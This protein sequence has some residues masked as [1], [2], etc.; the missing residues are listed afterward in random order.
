MDPLFLA[1][2]PE[3][4]QP[5]PR[6]HCWPRQNNSIHTLV[7]Q[8]GNS[9]RHRKI[10]FSGSTGTDRK[11]HVELR[12]QIEIAPLI[13]TPRRHY[14]LPR[15]VE[16]SCAASGFHQFLRRRSRLFQGE[17]HQR[18]DFAVVEMPPFFHKLVVL[19]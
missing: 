11:H 1:A 17:S 2:S 3:K 8:R 9:F 4:P 6:F 15:F 7:Q 12:D 5:L 18:L 14:F 19:L 13:R 16:R 10:G